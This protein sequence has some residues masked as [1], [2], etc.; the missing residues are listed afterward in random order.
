MPGKAKKQQQSS[1]DESDDQQKQS[2]S[3]DS[4]VPQVSKK[5]ELAQPKALKV[6]KAVKVVKAS[7]KVAKKVRQPEVEEKDDCGD[8]FYSGNDGCC[9]PTKLEKVSLVVA[10]KFKVN[11]LLAKEVDSK[12]VKSADVKATKLEVCEKSALKGETQVEG[13]LKVCAD[14]AL[15]GSMTVI[16]KP[17]AKV[18]FSA[19]AVYPNV[20]CGIKL[21][22]S[23]DVLVEFSQYSEFGACKQLDF[24]AA[25]K[26]PVKMGVPFFVGQLH[27]PTKGV[28]LAFGE[29]LAVSIRP[30]LFPP[31]PFTVK[32]GCAFMDKSSGAVYVVLADNAPALALVDGV[33]QWIDTVCEPCEVKC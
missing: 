4:D 29:V 12:L 2:D 3:S 21:E 5:L 31:T 18:L 9:R 8:D 19:G 1:S 32:T 14:T 23:P 15:A 30:P 33:V 28:G 26:G 24:Q 27:L 20:A 6:P 16:G 7:K 25:A 11:K 17:C 10:K 22:P 13:C